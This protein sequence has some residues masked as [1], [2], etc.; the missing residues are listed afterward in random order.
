LNRITFATFIQG[1]A[2][3]AYWLYI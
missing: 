1:L 2:S 3:Y